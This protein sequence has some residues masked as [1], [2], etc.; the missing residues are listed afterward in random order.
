M[1]RPSHPPR[2]CPSAPP[3][4]RNVAVLSHAE[5]VH[6]LTAAT[7]LRVKAALS[8]AAWW[9]WPLTFWPW[10]WWDVGYL[11]SNFGLPRPLCFSS[12]AQCKRETDVRRQTDVRQKHRLMPRLLGA[13]HNNDDDDNDDDDVT[14]IHS[15]AVTA[16]AAVKCL[17]VV[18]PWCRYRLHWV[19][20]H[21]LFMFLINWSLTDC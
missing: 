2:G 18:F 16:D 19:P 10:K 15:P 9:P 3:S 4:R 5:Y 1:P 14:V 12:Y 17:G 20:V 6:T 21:N 8:K 13:G 11:C 7:A